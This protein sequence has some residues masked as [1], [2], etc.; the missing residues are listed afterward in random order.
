MH[1]APVLDPRTQAVVTALATMT[2]LLLLI[3]LAA[4]G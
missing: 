3:A 4:A 1:R 2:T